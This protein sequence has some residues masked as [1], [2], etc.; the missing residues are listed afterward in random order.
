MSNDQ[1]ASPPDPTAAL[2]AATDALD[3]AAVVLGRAQEA[4]QERQRDFGAA[5]E[6]YRA[7]KATAQ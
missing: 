6:A 7:S 2:A 1:P 4:L 5:L 3:L